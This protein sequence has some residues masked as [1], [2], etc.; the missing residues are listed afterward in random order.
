MRRLQP[1]LFST[2]VNPYL[3]AVNLNPDDDTRL[4]DVINI[5]SFYFH[6]LI[7]RILRQLEHLQ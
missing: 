3:Q 4:A 6:I 1:E 2:K 7:R 5:S